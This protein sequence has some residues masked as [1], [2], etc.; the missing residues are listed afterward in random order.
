MVFYVAQ[1]TTAVK[2]CWARDTLLI[3]LLVCISVTNS[4]SV[5]NLKLRHHIIMSSRK[6]LSHQQF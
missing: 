2:L 5:D 1:H 6:P 3:N 4:V